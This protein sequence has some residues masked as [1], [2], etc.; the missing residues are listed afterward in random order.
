MRINKKDLEI[1]VNR[2][3]KIT[4]SPME[5]A[6]KVDGKYKIQVGHF[7]LDGAYGGWKLV[8]TV[9]D[10]GAIEE[11]TYGFISKRELYEKMKAY[12]S[13]LEFNKG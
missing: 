7:H 13:G 1:L 8:R 4:N 11:I 3:N 10:G 5:Y 2:I 9:N 6:L 12:L